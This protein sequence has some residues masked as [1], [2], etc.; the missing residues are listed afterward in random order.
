M[1][2]ENGKKRTEKEENISLN[3]MAKVRVEQITLMRT[4][5]FYDQQSPHTNFHLSLIFIASYRSFYLKESGKMVEVRRYE[6]TTQHKF[7]I[8]NVKF[9]IFKVSIIYFLAVNQL[10]LTNEANIIKVNRVHG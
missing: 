5:S 9:E 3:F 10:I 8:Y 2:R 4:T 6:C 7:A 1:N